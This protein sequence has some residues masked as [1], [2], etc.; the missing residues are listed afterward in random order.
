MLIYERK[1]ENDE[2]CKSIIFPNQ[3]PSEIFYINYAKE[4]NISTHLDCEF[5]CLFRCVWAELYE[6]IYLN[7]PTRILH[8]IEQEVYDNKCYFADSKHKYDKSNIY[9][10]P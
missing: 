1:K 4:R 7:K 5:T 8:T 9:C 10:M 3:Y 6:L 2:A